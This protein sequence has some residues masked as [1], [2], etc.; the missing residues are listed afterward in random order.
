MELL[1][2]AASLVI[3]YAVF[4]MWHAMWVDRDIVRHDFKNRYKS[5]KEIKE[6][7]VAQQYDATARK[8][9]KGINKSDG[10]TTVEDIRNGA[11]GGTARFVGGTYSYEL[12]NGNL[13]PSRC[14]TLSQ[15]TNETYIVVKSAL[16]ARFNGEFN[17]QDFKKIVLVLANLRGK[18]WNGEGKLDDVPYGLLYL[19]E[20]ILSVE[21]GYHESPESDLKIYR[22]V[23]VAELKSCGVPEK[24][25]FG[26]L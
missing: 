18:D 25:I 1:I 16:L 5:D 2:I 3:L 23:I 22:D 24:Y 11:I 9:L 21:A 8:Y 14:I 12:N 20:S 26:R 15:L 4:K 17:H 13:N 6:E 10:E 7:A 19:V